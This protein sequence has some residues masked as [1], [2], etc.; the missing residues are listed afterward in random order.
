MRIDEYLQLEEVQRKFPGSNKK[1]ERGLPELSEYAYLQHTNSDE[2]AQCENDVDFCLGQLQAANHQSKIA[3]L[4]GAIQL[5]NKLVRRNANVDEIVASRIIQQILADPD[6]IHNDHV[7]LNG[8]R[9]EEPFFRD[10]L[11][12]CDM[13][14][15]GSLLNS[16]D[17]KNI[18]RLMKHEIDTEFHPTDPNE[19]AKKLEKP[20]KIQSEKVAEYSRSKLI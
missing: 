3:P 18:D 10:L 13:A 12:K 15:V 5:S 7:L 16:T 8:Q 14:I 11:A 4:K 6:V 9:L 20:G 2:R 17:I 19:P 1:L